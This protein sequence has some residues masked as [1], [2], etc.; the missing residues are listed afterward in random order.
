MKDIK[1]Q[2]RTDKKLVVKCLVYFDK[3]WIEEVRKP[4]T[5]WVCGMNMWISDAT[6]KGLPEWYIG[7]NLRRFIPAQDIEEE[8]VG[9]VRPERAD[10]GVTAAEV[11]GEGKVKIE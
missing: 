9:D 5:D 2:L 11:E 6:K 8:A 1:L 7:K 10:C 3:K 4:R